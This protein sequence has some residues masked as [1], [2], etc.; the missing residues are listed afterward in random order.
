MKLTPS[1]AGLNAEWTWRR[2]GLTLAAPIMT[3]L[4]VAPALTA[5]RPLT[6]ADIIRWL[7]Q[8]RAEAEAFRKAAHA[9]G[10]ASATVK[11]RAAQAAELQADIS[12]GRKDA[13]EWIRAHATT[14]PIPAEAIYSAEC[15]RAMTAEGGAPTAAFTFNRE[16]PYRDL[17][18][19]AAAG[20]ETARDEFQRRCGE[21][22]RGERSAVSKAARDFARSIAAFYRDRGFVDSEGPTVSILTTILISPDRSLTVRISEANI[23]CGLLP[24]GLPPACSSLPTGP[25]LEIQDSGEPAVDNAPVAVGPASLGAATEAEA[26]PEYEAVKE[27]LFLARSDAANPTAL[28]CE[29]PSDAPAEVKQELAVIAAGYSLR[30]ANLLAYRR[31]ESTLAPL[32]DAF[33]LT[34]PE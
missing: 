3:L 33:L 16:S 13:L 19:R 2:T 15:S 1:A 23:Y 24:R 31:H 17:L 7:P 34:P 5:E 10:E 14:L 32:L 26:D 4:A 21:E 8:L 28:D 18:K 20:D 29:I 22:E 9:A 11:S 25:L 27:A 12:A 6:D 30:K